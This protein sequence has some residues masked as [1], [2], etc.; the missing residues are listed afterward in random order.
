[1]E[2]LIMFKKWLSVILSVAGVLAFITGCS[3]NEIDRG[4]T[5]Q[6]PKVTAEA[7][8]GEMATKVPKYVFMFIGDGMSQ[9]QVNSAQV[10][11]GSNVYGDVRTSNLSFTQFPVTGL[12]TTQNSSSFVPD[13]ASTATS[14]SSGVK[15]HSG[16]IGLNVDKTEATKTIAE[17]MK[18]SGKKVGIVS[19]VTLNHATPAAYYAHVESRGMYYEIANQLAESNFDYFG[20]GSLSQPTGK[21]N[22]QKDAFEIIKENGYTIANTKADILALDENSGKVYAVSPVLQDGG[23]LPYYI[24]TKKGD[25]TLADFVQKGIDVLDN[26]E[27][28]FMMV[29]SGKVDWSCHANDAM[30]AIQEV[31]GFESAIDVAIAFANEHPEET[32]IVV[33]GDHETGGMSIGF[34]ATGYDTAFNLLD[35]QKMSYV[36]FDE[37]VKAKKEENPNLTFEEMLPMIKENFGLLTADDEAAA[38][39][40]NQ[41]F[42]LSD[43]ELA[44]LQAGFEESMKAVE[45]RTS[46]EEN[47]LLYGGYDPLSVSLTHI[48]NNKAGIGWTSYAHTGTPVAVYAMGVGSEKFSGFYDNTDVYH[49]LVEVTGLKE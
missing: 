11:E 28:F 27:G 37:L 1:M 23:S 30:T 21:D 14:L 2:G 16:V 42:V 13:S 25:L 6:E 44:K 24:D 46:S 20:G 45:D 19:S 43:Y 41:A 36:A 7:K 35:A 29:E 39:K 38:V 9:V 5:S 31:L 17:Q 18:E 8:E 12:V 48:L 26:D 33:T 32:L 22:N 40:E 4:E 49:K 47:D 15:T 3:T 10:Y 34:A